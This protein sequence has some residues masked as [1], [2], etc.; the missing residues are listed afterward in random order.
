MRYFYLTNVLHLV[1]M[2]FTIV[3]G[4]FYSAR[5]ISHGRKGQFSAEQLLAYFI[6]TLF[7]CD[8]LLIFQN[9]GSLRNPSHPLQMELL[10]KYR[11]VYTKLMA[12]DKPEAPVK[13]SDE[14]V[15]KVGDL[16]ISTDKV[17]QS[18]SQN[19]NESS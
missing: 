6:L 19:L 13:K 2:N 5:V 14:E 10:N 4:A 15:K 16:E 18:K 11:L 8:L 3:N 1:V 9:I 17:S 12:K 7:V